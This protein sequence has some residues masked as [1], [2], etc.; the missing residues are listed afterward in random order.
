MQNVARHAWRMSLIQPPKVL[1]RSF[2]YTL[3]A[4]RLSM[5]RPGVRH[6]MEKRRTNAQ[7]HCMCRTECASSSR[8]RILEGICR[9]GFAREAF[10]LVSDVIEM[11]HLYQ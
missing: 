3:L 5:D 7:K 2:Q 1:R 9:E 6:R 8:E 11:I 10:P 4:L